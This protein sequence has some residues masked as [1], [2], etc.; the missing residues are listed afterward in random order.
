MKKIFTLC[1]ALFCATATFAQDD[2]D[3]NPKGSFVF[4]DKDGN[5]YEDGAV[6][7]RNEAEESPFGGIQIT[8]GLYVKQTVADLDGAPLLVG[9]S[10]DV[11]KIDNGDLQFCFPGSCR[12][13]EKVGF[14]D[15]SIIKEIKSGASLVTE[16]T[17][18]WDEDY[19]N[20][21]EGMATATFTLY[22]CQN[23]GTDKKPDYYNYGASSSITVNFV[24]GTTAVNGVV[25]NSKATVDAIYTVDGTRV[26]KMQ[27]GLNIVKLSNGK[28]MKIVN[29]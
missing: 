8:S 3:F 12:I 15:A 25:D 17:P 4:T 1:L 22:A 24:Y 27:K 26:Q 9:M 18:G 28:T 10:T 13:A 2:E 6:I 14:Y 5:V 21:L 11:K 29:K 7:T 19:E 23:V 16:W 20:Q